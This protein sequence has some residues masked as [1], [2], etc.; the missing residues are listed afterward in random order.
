MLFFY[1][2]AASNRFVLGFG[3]VNPVNVKGAHSELG[4]AVQGNGELDR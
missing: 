1:H 2:N 3:H 4:D